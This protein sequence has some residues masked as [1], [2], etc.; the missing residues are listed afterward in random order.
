MKEIIAKLNNTKM[1][2]RIAELKEK[3]M[4]QER[5]TSFEQARI[6]TEIYKKNEDKPI[7][8]K[9]ALSFKASC[10][11]LDIDIDDNELI[12][13]NRT[14]RPRDGVVFPEGGISWV[15]RDRRA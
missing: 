8:L 12:V 4:V 15:E 2:D 1:T 5:F 10:E 6:I 13:G 11:R 9:R 7:A 14:K 3:S